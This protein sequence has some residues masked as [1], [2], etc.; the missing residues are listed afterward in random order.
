MDFKLQYILAFNQKTRNPTHRLSL[1]ETELEPIVLQ[2][3]G[4]EDTWTLWR[5]AKCKGNPN[6]LPGHQ[7][8][9]NGYFITHRCDRFSDRH[10]A[11]VRCLTC[12]KLV[13]ITCLSTAPDIVQDAVFLHKL[14][15]PT[16]EPFQL[17]HVCGKRELD[18]RRIRTPLV[19]EW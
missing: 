16:C 7:E 12:K 2:S 19:L 11:V 18:A 3:K 5:Q 13:C 8:T 14:K 9:P 17:P 4:E 1:F 10:R 15:T 6:N